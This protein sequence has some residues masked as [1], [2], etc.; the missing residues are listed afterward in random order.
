ML[1]KIRVRYKLLLL[2]IVFLVGLSVFSGISLS[3]ITKIRVNGALYKNI[4]QGKD[5]VA[6]ILPPPEY[7]IELH[8]T[9]Y[10]M[11][12]ETNSGAIED[13]VKYAKTLQDSYEQRHVIW[14]KSLKSDEMKT[15][16]LEQSYQPVQEYFS[17]FNEDYVAA[18]RAGDK[19]QAAHILNNRLVPLYQE[20][21]SAIDRVVILANEQ[22]AALEK[23]ANKYIQDALMLFMLNF[24]CTI[25][26]IVI[27]SNFI[28]R[29]ITLPLDFL[30]IHLQKIAA[31]NLKEE[32]PGRWLQAT[33]ELG[34]ITKAAKQMQDSLR[35]IMKS[36]IAETNRLN[37]IADVCK[38][39]IVQITDSI[40]AIS[41]TVEELSA[42]MEET[43]SS[44]EEI[45][46][47]SEQIG[48]EVNHIV[49]QTQVGADSA[50]EINLKAIALKDSSI[51]LQKEAETTSSDIKAV[52]DSALKQIKAVDRIK[53]LTEV[54]LD[55][56]SETNLLALNAAI[57]SARAGEA[58][59][60]F[61]VVADQIR[62]LAENSEQAVGEIQ[63]TVETIILAVGNLTSIS[64]R[65]LD[66]I[67]TKVMDSYK[68]SVHVGE[69]YEKDADY[70]SNFVTEVNQI[71]VNLLT[72]MESVVNS[73]EGI[74]AA[75]HEGAAGTV[76]V[77]EQIS[78]VEKKADMVRS[79]TNS[80]KDSIE[81]LNQ[82]VLNFQM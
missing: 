43:A 11:L 79:E 5:V 17:I 19:V 45:N 71:S 18:I 40:N 60:G 36:I 47:I 28:M 6:D 67:E 74:A 57:E 65:T 4:I 21:R 26:V 41:S 72:S 61:A 10:Q 56:S 9:A 58:G 49:G 80:L 50:R 75:S 51:N 16:F 34:N 59:R 42:G 54:I 48:D 66:Y 82:L 76:E 22:S 39:H 3:I 44:T 63:A 62:K 1:K 70:V 25:L 2:V 7:I 30:K 68:E 14:E 32:I 24:L 78:V 73:L 23:T 81:N 37:Q 69:N 64:K 29:S 38:E 55:I 12:N 52:M 8:L 15:V 13:F 35:G 77:A 33:D 53:I 27:F 31:G 46:A 20:H